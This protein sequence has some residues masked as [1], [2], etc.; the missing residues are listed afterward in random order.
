MGKPNV[1]EEKSRDV[2]IPSSNSSSSSRNDQ[3]TIV[4][5]LNTLPA[6]KKQ[7]KD[8]L[9]VGGLSQLSKNILIIHKELVEKYEALENISLSSVEE[10]EQEQ[11]TLHLRKEQYVKNLHNRRL[12]YAMYQDA[13]RGIIKYY[14][15]E[16]SKPNIKMAFKRRL[17]DDVIKFFDN[18]LKHF[19]KK[20]KR[21]QRLFLKLS[22]ME[23]KDIILKK[24]FRCL[25]ILGDLER[26]K[27][28][29]LSL[30]TFILD[31]KKANTYYF[32]AISLNKYENDINPHLLLGTMASGK[33]HHLVSLYHYYRAVTCNPPMISILKSSGKKKKNQVKSAP[34]QNV[35][36]FFKDIIENYSTWNKS[37]KYA[38]CASL[39]NDVLSFHATVFSYLSFKKR[40]ENNNDN[41]DIVQSP[42][43]TTVTISLRQ[44]RNHICKKIKL[45][46]LQPSLK[47]KKKKTNSVVK[48]KNKNNNP[49]TMSKSKL[50]P[51]LYIR[52]MFVSWFTIVD[53]SKN[54]H[55]NNNNNNNNNTNFMLMRRTFSPQLST[56]KKE[57]ILNLI[58]E[59]AWT[60]YIDMISAYNIIDN[61]NNLDSSEF[62]TGEK[63]N[64]IIGALPPL[65][66]IGTTLFKDSDN[67][68][69]NNNDSISSDELPNFFIHCTPLSQ[70]M[71]FNYI[72]NLHNLYI[73]DMK[74]VL[75]EAKRGEIPPVAVSSSSNNTNNYAKYQPQTVEEME[76]YGFS[77][78]DKFENFNLNQELNDDIVENIDKDVQ[79]KLSG[80]KAYYY[81]LMK[82]NNFVKRLCD[83]KHVFIENDNCVCYIDRKKN[84]NSSAT[85]N[86]ELSSYT[87]FNIMDDKNTRFTASKSQIEEDII[88]EEHHQGAVGDNVIAEEEQVEN[89]VLTN[90]NEA[91]LSDEI[92]DSQDVD[93][94]H[95]S[96]SSSSPSIN[97]NSSPMNSSSS[98]PMLN[99]NNNN[100]FLSSHAKRSISRNSDININNT[101]KDDYN[102]ENED[103]KDNHNQGKNDKH[104]QTNGN[105]MMMMSAMDDDDDDDNNNNNVLVNSPDAVINSNISNNNNKKRSTTRSSSNKS[106]RD[107]D[108]DSS[109]GNDTGNSV[110]KHSNNNDNNRVYI[111]DSDEDNIDESSRIRE[112]SIFYDINRPSNSRVNNEPPITY[113]SYLISSAGNLKYEKEQMMIDEYVTLPFDRQY[114]SISVGSN[115][116][117]FGISKDKHNIAVLSTEND[118]APLSLSQSHSSQNSINNIHVIADNEFDDDHHK[119]PTKKKKKKINKKKRKRIA[120]SDNSIKN[121]TSLMMVNTLNQ[122]YGNDDDGGGGGNNNSNKKKQKSTSHLLY[123]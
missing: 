120:T 18:S 70:R 100:N 93:N 61:N 99:N 104:L 90:D 78:L 123:L 48:K 115:D 109:I 88:S 96:I 72:V 113:V 17:I 4:N 23:D 41:N 60:L 28:G 63:E 36:S 85:T 103:E 94:D 29:T 53:I 3:E 11:Q 107:I 82:L 40:K 73:D 35:K 30:R 56:E 122:S 12:A 27:A 16:I 24:I 86:G 31:Y 62:R 2:M 114:R 26:Y 87:V 118:V 64:F 116:R 84:G 46:V 32:Q 42:T 58:R 74:I 15:G 71:F 119:K 121:T 105:G 76:L 51:K 101:M 54:S 111:Y 52:M 34:L 67:D 68:S 38:S 8:I 5:I 49:G 98:S 91:L 14:R 50:P 1:K 19:E 80:M 43:T 37:Q 44:L 95:S 25:T 81:R 110:L 21:F 9:N 20:L 65:L 69:N 45:L 75:N 33:E 47:K 102:N 106:R 55:N 10:Q 97:I 66:L 117:N 92:G 89:V 83:M 39:C 77:L 57:E 7:L 59:N 79:P 6:K 22:P 13:Y 108:N 112:Q